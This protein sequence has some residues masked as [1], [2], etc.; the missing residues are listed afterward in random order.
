[1]QFVSCYFKKINLRVASYFLRAAVLKESTC[2]MNWFFFFFCFEKSKFCK[3]K[4]S[5]RSCVFVLATCA[6]LLVTFFKQPKAE[7]WLWF[8]ILDLGN[9][10][11]RT[12][13]EMH[14]C[15]VESNKMLWKT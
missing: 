5:L 1:M 8:L 11:Q 3:L 7:V 13:P 2:E 14:F 12:C 6:F 15:G 4:I 10:K 9:M